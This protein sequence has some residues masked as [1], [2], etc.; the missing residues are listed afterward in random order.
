L[1]TRLPLPEFYRELVT[2]QRAIYRKHLDWRQL[3]DASGIAAR[4]VLRG[5][6][7]FVKSLFRLG[8][9]YR[10]ELLLADHSAPAVYQIPLPPNATDKHRRDGNSL[11]IHAPRGRKGRTIDLA[12]ERFV[13]QGRTGT[14]P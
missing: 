13:E 12:T 11:Y 9:V 6:T 3:W 10:P 2:T 5:Q 7:N 8:S 1:P 4:L 14:A